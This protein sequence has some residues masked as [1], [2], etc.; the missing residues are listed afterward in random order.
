MSAIRKVPLIEQVI[1]KLTN[2]EK[3]D[4]QEW[5][6]EG[7][8]N[9]ECSLAN[10]PNGINP[11]YFKLD[12]TIPAR[13]GLLMNTSNVCALIAYHRY[14]DLELYIIDKTTKTYVKSKEY[15]DIN[16]LRRV[17]MDVS[18]S[19]T[20]L[21]SGDAEL[22]DVLVS[23][24][25]GGVQFVPPR[26]VE[27]TEHVVTFDN[28][29]FTDNQVSLPLSEGDARWDYMQDTTTDCVL[30][31]R[32]S[33][34]T[35]VEMR[36]IHYDT[37]YV[38]FGSTLN[39]EVDGNGKYMSIIYSA[40]FAET[41]GV[42]V[43]VE[44]EANKDLSGDNTEYPYLSNITIGGETYYVV[45]I[46]LI[47]EINTEL[48]EKANKDGYYETFGYARE[49]GIAKNLQN[50]EGKL[51]DP[52]VDTS[53]GTTY[54]DAP[55]VQ[56]ATAMTMKAYLD[57]E[58][59]TVGSGYEQW[60]KEQAFSI[61]RNQLLDKDDFPAT[62]TINGITFTNNG[63]GS[64]TV[65][66]TATDTAYIKLSKDNIK[67]VN[68]KYLLVG[69]PSGGSGLSGYT[70]WDNQRNVFDNGSGVIYTS[71]NNSGNIFIRVNS[72]TV[73][74]NPITFKPKW[75]DLT[76][77]FASRPAIATALSGDAGVKW[78]LQN[79]PKATTLAYDEGTIVDTED[80]DYETTGVQLWDEE[81]E[82]GYY[83]S[84]D[85]TKVSA[86]DRIRSKNKIAII[87][88]S[89]IALYCAVANVG[90]RTVCFYDSNETFISS[91]LLDTQTSFQTI[92]AP[93]NASFM[94][95]NM[96]PNYGTTYN[97]NIQI[98]NHFTET[99]V[100]QTYH[101]FEIFRDRISW[102]FTSTGKGKSAGSVADTKDYVNFKNIEKAEQKAFTGLENW[103]FDGT[104]GYWYTNN[105]IPSSA[106]S[107][108]DGANICSNNIVLTIIGDGRTIRAYLSRNPSLSSSSNMNEI[109]KAGT[110]MNYELATPIE[111]DMSGDEL[112]TN[113][114]E[115]DY[116][117]ERKVSV[118]GNMFSGS[119][120]TIFYQDNVLRQIYNNKSAID[121]L[122]E[123]VA[124]KQDAMQNLS[125]Q[126]TDVAGLTYAVKKAY[127]IGNVVTL[128]IL[129][130]NNTGSEIAV[131]LP[132][133][134]LSSNIRNANR[135]L[136]SCTVGDTQTY[137]RIESNVS[138]A[139]AI[140]NTV[141]V[142]ICI[143]YAVA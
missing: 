103:I 60:R 89:T 13:S 130:A 110:T 36:R 73:I 138:V 143:T 23:D 106:I 15:L 33:S 3:N 135:I 98:C 119:A 95:F 77:W 99:S 96:A 61:V 5:L 64:I 44:I 102:A 122:Q 120:T 50:D 2:D 47:N 84:S 81:W 62:Q 72:G 69:C 136:V 114:P 29:T 139:V 71:L 25:Q 82:L 28:V 80:Y 87:P 66:G 78:F 116:G 17:L 124:T 20:D 59:I 38:E 115:N 127:K 57:N 141:S 41:G 12:E 117:V 132:L 134:S 42:A 11:V 43:I 86:T 63:D 55:F 14:Q 83:S 58:L 67:I 75:I 90:I 27:S 128:T 30:V 112:D 56:R 8:S 97:N 22:G 91:A 131:N 48:D 142:N 37:D 137:A 121:N 133:F 105:F 18:F 6:D 51:L 40:K 7:G 1:G 113:I 26:E 53:S 34:G 126:I 32:L 92:T 19:A 94:V 21:D 93:S 118:S 46:A 68:H 70:L 31:L 9:I 65:S 35:N 52:D 101:K 54:A 123:E 109:F 88:S 108:I 45:D 100:E 10:M 49:A 24:G 79:Y 39:Q 76:Q 125:D 4:L 16:E 107:K 111:T 85:G 74:S 129:A 140:P 104:N